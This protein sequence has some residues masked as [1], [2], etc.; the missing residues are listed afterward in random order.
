[1]I[2]KKSW[3]Y[4]LCKDDSYWCK[5][6]KYH[7]LKSLKDFSDVAKGNFGGYVQGYHNLSQFGDCWIYG[8]SRVS[9]HAK[10]IDNA[11]V[12]NNA[13]IMD[14]A[15]IS[16]NAVISQIRIFGNAVVSGFTFRDVPF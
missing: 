6:Y 15:I 7:R 2:Y 9:E 13:W 1:M 11:K 4:I 12:I 16:E 3:K 14:N 8:N 5:D 10:V